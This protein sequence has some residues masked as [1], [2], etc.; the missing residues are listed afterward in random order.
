MP[1]DPS[2][3]H[4]HV[5]S[6]P[7]LRCLL[8]PRASI[9]RLGSTFMRVYYRH[10]WIRCARYA[11]REALVVTRAQSTAEARVD[12]ALVAA[13]TNVTEEVFRFGFLMADAILDAFELS[14]HTL[15]LGLLLL[16][17]H[18][19]GFSSTAIVAEFADEY[20]RVVPEL[21]VSEFGF[22][23][24][25]AAILRHWLRRLADAE[26]VKE[27]VT[28]T[29]GKHVAVARSLTGTIGLLD[30]DVPVCQLL[31]LSRDDIANESRLHSYWVVS[32][33]RVVN[34]VLRHRP[35]RH[36]ASLICQLA[37]PCH[38]LAVPVRPRFLFVGDVLRDHGHDS[39]LFDLHSGF[40]IPVPL[41]QLGVIGI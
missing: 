30:V 16:E 37:R 12:D 31:C 6:D 11:E 32:P 39:F 7:R 8:P 23:V 26:G 29:A 1:E 28:V 21:P 36:V 41:Q 13:A 2:A 24:F 25:V 14:P 40:L 20:L 35:L 18:I 3:G 27:Q 19:P 34:A 17:G 22:V 15:P 5:I 33:V 4:H 10:L 9:L 38:S